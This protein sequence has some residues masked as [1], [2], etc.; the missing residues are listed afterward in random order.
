MFLATYINFAD[1][2][3]QR[4]DEHAVEET[5]QKALKVDPQNG[6][7]LYALGLSLL[8][9]KRLP[10][11]IATL[12]KAADLRV[13]EPRYAYVHGV[14][15]HDAGQGQRGLEVLENAHARHPADRQIVTPLAEYHAEAGHRDAA[16]AW[17]RRLVDLSPGRGAARRR[18][19]ELEQAE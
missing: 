7:A 16:I 1:L 11:A 4:G 5:L 2:Y 6:P 19:A 10:E 12:A 9:Q 18:L 15:L 17:A 13:D 3:R 8:R 14:A